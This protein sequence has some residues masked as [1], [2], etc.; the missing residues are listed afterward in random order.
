MDRRDSKPYNGNRGRGGFNRENREMH[1][2]TCADCGKE[3][4]VPFVPDPERPVYCRE[5]L[6][7]HRTSRR[8]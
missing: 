2:A 3:T 4:E 1:S 5:C 6:P 8:F 7:S